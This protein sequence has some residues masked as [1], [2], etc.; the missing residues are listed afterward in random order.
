VDGSE[1]TFEIATCLGRGGF[2]EVYRAR[3]SRDGGLAA[4]VALKVLRRDIDPDG[5]AVQRLRDEGRLLSQLNHPSIL[6][7]HDLV[8]LAGRIALITEYV[9]GDDLSECLDGPD[10]PADPTGR[11]GPRALLQVIARVASALDAA[12]TARTPDSD[13]PLR[14]VHRDIKPSNIRLSRHGDVKLL[15]FGIARTDA[16]EREARTRTDMMVGSPA[17][18]APERFLEK[19]VLLESD[20]FSL[21]AVLFEGLAGERFYGDLPVPMQVGLAVDPDRFAHHLDGRLAQVEDPALEAL[22]RRTLA[23]DPAERPPPADLAHT[24]DALADRMTGPTLARYCRAR[25]WSDGASSVTGELDGTTVTEGMERPVPAERTAASVPPPDPTLDT[26]R[27]EPRT[28]PA[29]ATLSL[30]QLPDI[31]APAEP[32]SDGSLLG[33]ALVGIGGTG[34]LAIG[35]IGLLALIGVVT[36]PFALGPQEGDPQ[37]PAELGGLQDPSIGIPPEPVPPAP[38]PQPQPEEPAAPKEPRPPPRADPEPPAPEPAAAPDPAAVAA[39]DSPPVAA[40]GPSPAPPP[41]PAGPPPG[42]VEVEASFPVYVVGPDGPIR[43]PGR[44]PPG[45]WPIRAAFNGI[46][47]VDANATVEVVS[48]QTATVRCSDRFQRCTVD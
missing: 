13:G 24:C 7:V 12:W 42:R 34:V 44:L 20:V 23:A 38:E 36:L 40:P 48:D 9:D 10:D 28:A 19:D 4:D 35:A 25:R 27:P 16:V 43:L 21:G 29:D 45:S 37:P 30:E 17:Y 26:T 1:R 18:M 15:D 8:V 22:L 41:E 3:M 14:M 5:Q 46:E 6:K 33:W 39:P 32:E 31:G 2:G 11:I 47:V